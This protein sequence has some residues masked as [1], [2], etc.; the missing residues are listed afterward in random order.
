MRPALCLD[1]T[2]SVNPCCAPKPGPAEVIYHL[3]GQYKPWLTADG[4]RKL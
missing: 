1:F 2:V 4:D 3:Q